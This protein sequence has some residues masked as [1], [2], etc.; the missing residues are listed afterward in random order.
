MIV[1]NP[2][3]I[4]GG[5]AERAP[6]RAVVT[7]AEVWA[8][9]D[10]VDRRYRAMVL[11]AGFVGLRKG[12]L[13]GLTP[14]RVDLLHGLITIAEQYQQLKDGRLVLGPP[15][16]EAGRRTLAIPPP[17]VAEIE[18]HLA[19]FA[20]PG[21]DG[22]VFPGGRAAPSVRRSGRPSGTRLG[23]RWGYRGCTSMTSA[24]SQTRSRRRRERVPRS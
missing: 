19:R 17:L 11:L 15:K 2:C 10:A 4:D 5:G 6:E 9:A 20:G 14:S 16:T 23:G 13:F 21:P 24:T 8:L 22:L 7:A 3:V 12:Q 1:K 18:A